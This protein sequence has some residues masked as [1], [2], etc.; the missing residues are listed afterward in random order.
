MNRQQKQQFVD[1]L[2]QKFAKA[3]AAFIVKCQGLTVNQMQTLR[4]SLQTNG[5]NLQVSKNRLSK[6]ALKNM[7]GAEELHDYLKGQLAVVFA[8]DNVTGVAKSLTTFAKTNEKLEII[9]G[10][11][12]SQIFTAKQVRAL[13]NIPSR[14]VLLAQLCGILNA[15]ITKLVSVL[16]Q[17]AKK[18]AQPAQETAL[19]QV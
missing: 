2:S 7:P 8:D 9:A 10:C 12:E 16:D 15:P 5:A 4:F 6:L 11:F 17:V 18:D 19:E 3:Q 14:E 13:G 1:G